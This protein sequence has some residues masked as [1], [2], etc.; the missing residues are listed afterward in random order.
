MTRGAWIAPALLASALVSGGAAA[1]VA[2]DRQDGVGHVSVTASCSAAGEKVAAARRAVK[3]AQRAL[4]KAETR[5]TKARARK[6]LRKAKS[7]R[8]NAIAAQK[9]A[10]APVTNPP[11]NA[12]AAPQLGAS[13]PGSPSNSNNLVVKGTAAAGTTVKLYGAPNC[14]G[15]PA[16]T[17][18]A[19]QF[20]SGGL[21]VTVL[22][23][24]TTTFRGTATNAAG[25]T[26]GCSPSSVSYVE[27]SLPPAPPVLTG[28]SPVSPAEDTS[29]QI[30]GTAEPGSTVRVYSDP[31]CA[32][33]PAATGDAGAFGVGGLTVTVP[34]NST[35]TFR[36]TASDA[37]ENTSACSPTSV[38]YVQQPPNQPPSFGAQQ[39]TRVV[40]NQYVIVL[41]QVKL[42][43][44][45]VGITLSPGA[46]DPDGDPLSYTWEATN[47]SI[48]GNGLSATWVRAIQ[49]YLVSPGTAT[50]TAS[51]GRGGTATY[52]M[53]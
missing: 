48:T 18:P 13:S 7:R 53:N 4:R 46:T 37:V 52:T 51:D 44:Q 39:I 10:C 35:T 20:G 14:S 30:T 2:A 43:A 12:P 49:N 26:S 22:D 28:T 50:V 25:A 17:G 29:P 15:A 34:G 45:T 6:R 16:A 32:G 1:H 19:A 21:P 33:P 11:A 31:L 27:D 38:V 41:G 9:K 24:S 47:G 8:A 3:R 40:S 42:S 5:G 36:A 23:N